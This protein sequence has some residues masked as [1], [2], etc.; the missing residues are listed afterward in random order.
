MGHYFCRFRKKWGR[1]KTD[2]ESLADVVVDD[3]AGDEELFGQRTE[4]LTDGQLEWRRPAAVL[5]VEI[6]IAM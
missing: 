1:G 3:G 5:G 6:D 2:L 4:F